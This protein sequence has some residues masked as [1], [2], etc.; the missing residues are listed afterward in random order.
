MRE[1]SLYLFVTAFVGMVL[2]VFPAIVYIYIMSR[3]ECELMIT[4]KKLHS[5]Y[6][7]RVDTITKISLFFTGI[8]VVT[9]LDTLLIYGDKEGLLKYCGF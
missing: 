8:M 4:D 5:K 9:V 1:I 3:N 6:Q 2:S 7:K